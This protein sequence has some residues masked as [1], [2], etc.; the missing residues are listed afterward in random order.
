MKYG[1]G[2][3]LML[4]NGASARPRRITF[5]CGHCREVIETTSDPAVLEAHRRR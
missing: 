3:W 5:R 2:A 1:V 4:F